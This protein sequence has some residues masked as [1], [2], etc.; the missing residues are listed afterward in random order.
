MFTVHIIIVVVAG[1]QR[2]I[3]LG[4]CQIRVNINVIETDIVFH[5]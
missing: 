1:L 3:G 2:Q 5:Y 4:Q